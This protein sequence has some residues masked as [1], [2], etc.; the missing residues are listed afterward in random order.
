MRDLKFRVWE[1]ADGEIYKMVCSDEYASL[2]EYVT[3]HGLSS[4]HMQYTGLKDKNNKDIYE[5]DILL[6]TSKKFTKNGE[7]RGM[8]FYQNCKA[9][10]YLQCVYSNAIFGI[11]NKLSQVNKHSEIIGNIHENRGLLCAQDK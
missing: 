3:Y 2:L 7:D 9:R 10:F 11:K 6:I 5:G 1:A 8:V 4:D